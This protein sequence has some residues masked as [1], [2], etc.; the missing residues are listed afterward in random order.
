MLAAIFA[1]LLILISIILIIFI[2]KI[3]ANYQSREISILEK[4]RILEENY[5][6]CNQQNENLKKRYTEDKNKWQQYT[7]NLKSEVEKLAPYKTISNVEQ[8]KNKL[9]E[10]AKK[11]SE[12]IINSAN[13]EK[14]QADDLF[15]K[16]RFKLLEVQNTQKQLEEYLPILDAK[17]LGNSIIKK[18]QSEAQKI[19]EEA[20]NRVKDL[21]KRSQ[22]L[23]IYYRQISEKIQNQE[24]TLKQYLPV[25]DAVKLANDIIDKAK[26][27]A[28]KI[29]EQAQAEKNSVLSS[30]NKEL[31]S[32]KNLLRAIENSVKGYGNEYLIPN[33]S[34]FDDLAEDYSYI[35]AGNDLKEARNKSRFM[36]E[37][38]SAAVC[39]Y[40]ERVRKET[41]IKFILDSFNGK[42]DTIQAQAK[43]DNYG[44][45]K[46]KII[47]SFILVNS[48]GE[49]FRNARITEKYK[50]ARIEELRLAIIV[51]EYKKQFQEEQRAAREQAREEEKV[52][53]EHERQIKQAEREE[54]IVQKALNEAQ[55]R[56]NE[57]SAEFKE[58]YR[59]QLEE[60]Q[61]KLTEAEEKSRRAVSEAQKTKKG[62]VYII[63]NIGSFG[64]NVY[65]IGLTRRLDPAERV[66]ELGDASV[67][68]PF[69]IHA[70]IE[71]E[72]SPS[73]ETALHKYFILNQMNKVNPRKEFF[74]LSI[75]TIMQEVNDFKKT[76]GEEFGI[77]E[78]K[79][80]AAATA[81]EYRETL[82]REQELANDPEKRKIWENRQIKSIESDINIDDEEEK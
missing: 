65:K 59:V 29:I 51:N 13:F 21:T 50:E 45:L 47:D 48:H 70:M 43:T 22:D 31:E 52:R 10:D 72:D 63:S 60:L 44:K 11:E 17:E 3:K 40:A 7:N 9:I 1:I 81:Q 20:N 77:S 2:F 37:N 34:L 64:D 41:A 42:I 78:I 74:R 26:I 19:L 62:H 49:A 46:Q 82:I 76:H 54:K 14:K 39:D 38:D 79:W 67:P 16:A 6:S 30:I 75:D 15:I 32:R 8:Y 57:A 69:D 55:K 33:S 80:T 28:E 53:R 61:G 24:S 4:K 23:L 71:C 25:L 12:K 18:A 35:K 58:K 66:K 56:F 68:F 73:V 36:I 5:Y 27:E